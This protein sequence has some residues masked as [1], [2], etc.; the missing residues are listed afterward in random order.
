L[1]WSNALITPQRWLKKRLN[2]FNLKIRHLDSK[3]DRIDDNVKIIKGELEYALDEKGLLILH[4]EIENELSVGVSGDIIFEDNFRQKY[5]ISGFGSG[6]IVPQDDLGVK[7]I[8]AKTDT[9]IVCEPF[10]HND[11]EEPKRK[12]HIVWSGEDSCTILPASEQYH[13]IAPTNWQADNGELV[14]QQD[15]FHPGT[16]E[17]ILKTEAHDEI[18]ATTTIFQARES[19]RARRSTGVGLMVTAAGA[20]CHV[21]ELSDEIGINPEHILVPKAQ[22]TG[23]SINNRVN[24]DRMTH[25]Y[26]TSSITSTKIISPED[27]NVKL[28]ETMKTACKGKTIFYNSQHVV[29]SNGEKLKAGV[30]LG[31]NN[32]KNHH[33]EKL[34]PQTPDYT[35]KGERR[36]CRDV[37]NIYIRAKVSSC[38]TWVYSGRYDSTDIDELREPIHVHSTWTVYA[39]CCNDNKNDEGIYDTRFFPCEEIPY[40]DS[41]EGDSADAEQAFSTAYAL[42]LGKHYYGDSTHPFCMGISR[43]CEWSDDSD[44]YAALGLTVPGAC[45]SSCKSY[46]N[47]YESR[48]FLSN[49]YVQGVN[50]PNGCFKCFGMFPGFYDENDPYK[51]DPEFHNNDRY[52]GPCTENNLP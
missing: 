17:A 40:G 5:R 35:L 46:C 52:K 1:I 31:V 41:A 19:T 34:M 42:S 48:D 22:K 29:E 7:E 15:Y 11:D 45:T 33:L 23:R 38:G 9:G 6:E 36:S 12:F 39:Q 28:T 47:N 20:E 49:N 50:Y 8:T 14:A 37:K 43:F 3:T 2:A 10:V 30:V 51:V 24:K 25:K 16:R 18:L 4:I 26:V 27:E 13:H 21:N 32:S 44:K